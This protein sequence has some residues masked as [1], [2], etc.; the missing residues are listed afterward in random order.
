[1]PNHE[2][3]FSPDQIEEWLQ[4][5]TLDQASHNGTASHADPEL[6]L[7][8]DLWEL[9]AS[10]KA[11]DNHSLQRVW[12]RL[13]QKTASDV[14]AKEQTSPESE[15]HSTSLQPQKLPIP[16]KRKFSHR[17]KGWIKTTGKSIQV[18]AA[19]ILILVLVGSMLTIMTF[20]HQ[21]VPGISTIKTS[22]PTPTPAPVSQLPGYPPPG[23]TIAISPGSTDEISA[24]S[25]APDGKRLAGSTQGKAWIWDLGSGEYSQLSIPDIANHPIKA[26]S[27]SPDG[28]YLAIGTN[29]VQVIDTISNQIRFTY[30]IYAF[31]PVVGNDYQAVI[32]ALTWS[33]DSNLLAIAALRSG[34]GCVVQIRDIRQDADK[35]A[36]SYQSEPSSTGISSISWSPDGHFLSWADGQTVQVWD[37]SVITDTP[38][39]VF[40]QNIPHD[41]S[42][43]WS[44]STPT[45]LAFI[46]GSIAQV[47]NVETDTVVTQYMPAGNGILSWSPDGYYLASANDKQIDL[48][49]ASTGAHL[50]TYTGH[51]SYVN[52]LAWSPDGKY[53]ASGE[54]SSAS[55]QNI[56]RVWSA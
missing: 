10:E 36:N 6:L 8:Q 47:W 32:T 9:Y 49:N 4:T 21:L 30:P 45:L 33:H 18:L 34:N 39:P 37:T 44:P 26:L 46:N 51:T 20:N 29:P 3:F 38:T 53:L 11:R 12:E 19:S 22:T 28:Q 55:R 2:D 15:K 52:S 1:M 54:G 40:K 14:E 31:W 13:E 42:V 16:L 17:G 24:L 35:V 56:A 27:W 23:D 41:T 5:A 48:W 25:W 43:A 7:V 50:Y